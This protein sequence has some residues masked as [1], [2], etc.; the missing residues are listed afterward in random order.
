MWKERQQVIGGEGTTVEID[1][2]IWRKRK[3]RRGRKNKQGWILGGVERLEG[4]GAGERLMVVVPNRKKET[5][6]PIIQKHIKAG[7]LIIADEWRAYSSLETVGYKH[8]TVCHKRRFRDPETGAYTNTIEGLWQ[9]LRCTFHRFGTRIRLMHDYL[10]LFLVKSTFNL[11]FIQLIK[12]L[13]FEKEIEPVQVEEEEEKEEIIDE[14]EKI[15]IWMMLSMKIAMLN[16]MKISEQ[17][18]ELVPLNMSL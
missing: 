2:A 13:C 3:N 1:E 18:M 9:H 6:I 7:T 4:G 12:Y 15:A 14:D 11:T 16:L 5:L 10:S 17:E 8:Q